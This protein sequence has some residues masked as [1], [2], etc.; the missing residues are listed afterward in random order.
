MLPVPV[1]KKTLNVKWHSDGHGE[2][3]GER[4]RENKQ[5][6]WII[7]KVLVYRNSITDHEV[8][9]DCHHCDKYVTRRDWIHEAGRECWRSFC[10]ACVS[11][12]WYGSVVHLL[13]QRL[14]TESLSR[15]ALKKK[16]SQHW[17]FL[18]LI[19][20]SC[21]YFLSCP[22]FSRL[23]VK[24]VSEML[25]SLL[26]FIRQTGRPLVNCCRKVNRMYLQVLVKTNQKFNPQP[27]RYSLLIELKRKKIKSISLKAV[28]IKKNSI[29]MSFRS[30]GMQSVRAKVL[31]SL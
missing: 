10:G 16:N 31:F 18:Q 22:L 26:G 29:L 6:G 3:I 28:Y 12:L 1:L 24:E 20:S 30:A 27:L 17:L 5:V 7:A 8:S 2:E 21:G 4:Q 11:G 14:V 23:E 13:N 9:N 19:S 25:E 15:E